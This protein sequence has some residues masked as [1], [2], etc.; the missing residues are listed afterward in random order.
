MPYAEESQQD[1]FGNVDNTPTTNI[2]EVS[3]L[4]TRKQPH[5]ACHKA[6]DFKYTA[7][8]STFME[9]LEVEGANM[10]QAYFKIKA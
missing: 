10:I 6:A 7:A 4:S 3:V 2:D 5:R 9:Q 8:H 1:Y